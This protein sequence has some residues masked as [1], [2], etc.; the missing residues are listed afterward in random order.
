MK[1][2]YCLVTGATSGIGLATAIGLGRQGAHVGIVARTAQRGRIARNLIEEAT[3]RPV[4]VF[5]GDLSSQ[6]SVRTLAASVLGTWDRLDVLIHNAGTYSNQRQV[7]PEGLERTF[8]VNYLSRFLLTHLLLDRLKASAPARIIHVAGAYHAKGTIH[9]D[10]LQAQHRYDGMQANNQ[11]KL[12]DIL[13]VYELARRLEGSGVTVNALHPGAV[14][15]DLV[16]NDP[17][18]PRGQRFLYRLCRPFMKTPEQGAETPIHLALSPEVQGV[19]GRY[20]VDKREA[21]SSPA[22]HDRELARRLWEVS[23]DLCG[24][25]AEIWASIPGRTSSG[26]RTSRKVMTV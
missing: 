21:P 3:G 20:F 7:T 8:A 16:L 26:G 11:S 2:A 6:A 5:V 25:P 18:F 17:D 12:A 19:T 22:T 4:F 13:F 1:D 15:T 10:D 23:T 14:A 24:L 9:F